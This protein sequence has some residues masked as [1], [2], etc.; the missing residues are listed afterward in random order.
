[1]V[2][3]NDT[4]AADS[5]ELLLRAGGYSETRVAYTAHGALA[6][7]KEFCPAIVLIELDM[8]DMG[9]YELGNTLWE[10]SRLHRV[11]LIAVTD[12]RARGDR[13]CAGN[14]GFERYL[15]KPI[16]GADLCSCLTSPPPAPSE[17]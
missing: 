1:M 3:D 4:R 13:D 7:A 11:R 2:V 8:R 12:S 9:S 15:L 17:K 5:L 6:I 16:T 10:H 14:A